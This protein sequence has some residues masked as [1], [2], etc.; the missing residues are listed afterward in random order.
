VPGFSK[1]TGNSC[2]LCRQ[3]KLLLTAAWAGWDRKL[4]QTVSLQLPDGSQKISAPPLIPKLLSDLSAAQRPGSERQQH[5]ALGWGPLDM[6][7]IMSLHMSL[8]MS[9]SQCRMHR[10]F[11]HEVCPLDIR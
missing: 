5:M 6:S 1:R 7:L 9:L 4:D 11:H 3:S 8:I 10:K 2:A